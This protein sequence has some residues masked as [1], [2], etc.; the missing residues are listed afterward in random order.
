MCIDY[1]ALNKQTI[2]DVFP[3]PQIDSLLER[4]GQARVFSKLDLA[5][6][7]HQIE[8]KEQHIGKTA[9]RTSRGHYEFLV[10]PFDLCDA[11]ATFQRLMN[12]V[13]AAHIGDFICVYLD[14]ILVFSRNLDEH[15]MHLRQ[16]LERLRE[17]KLFGRLHKCEFLKERVD[18]LGFEVSP[19]GIHASPDKV[20]AIIE[21]PKPKDIHDLRSFLGLASYYIKFIRGFSEIA[22]PLTWLT[23][24]G[25][26]WEWS[27]SQRKAFNTLKLTLATAL[28]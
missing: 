8:V 15:W 12:K 24:K 11:P 27:E 1:R 17:A 7:Y 6:G 23:R 16:A 2:K 9:F 22:R 5:S 14:D 3:L 26:K 4:L 18:Y 13:F 28:S 21:W 20:R 25:A 10:M 19:E